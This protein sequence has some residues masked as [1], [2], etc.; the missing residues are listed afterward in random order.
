MSENEVAMPMDR[1]R[2]KLGVSASYFSAMKKVMGLTG[3]H[4]GTVK[5]FTEFIQSNPG[6]RYA[7][8]YHP[9]RCDCKECV[10][11]RAA[12]AERQVA[13]AA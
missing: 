11:K 13:V 6:F 10:Q 7:D 1:V 8:A 12:K 3:T 4:M 2:E 5:Q 9:R